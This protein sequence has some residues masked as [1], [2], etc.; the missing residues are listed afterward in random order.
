LRHQEDFI[1]FR[2]LP[3]ADYEA[4]CPLTLTHE[5]I[6]TRIFLLFKGVR[7]QELGIWKEAS[8]HEDWKEV[9]GIN[10]QAFD[11]SFVRVLE[12]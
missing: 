12:W 5:S 11:A 2:F 8:K 3:Q 4:A 10:P 9:V 1:A 6:I 7:K